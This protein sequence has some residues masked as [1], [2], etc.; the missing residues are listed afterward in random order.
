MGLTF[1][2]EAQAIDSRRK[3]GQVVICAMKKRT[4]VTATVSG[5]GR[6]GGSLR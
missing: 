2:L 6:N 5:G 4:P 1:P 3:I